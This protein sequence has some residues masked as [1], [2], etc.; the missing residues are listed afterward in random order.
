[1]KLAE[2]QTKYWEIL[3][4]VSDL[5][6]QHQDMLDIF[7]VHLLKPCPACSEQAHMV[8]EKRSMFIRCKKCGLKGPNYP[9]DPQKLLTEYTDHCTRKIVAW[10]EIPRENNQAQKEAPENKVDNV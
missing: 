7:S 6:S 2:L 8:Q 1:M 3:R 4:V 5:Q 10:N 9:Q